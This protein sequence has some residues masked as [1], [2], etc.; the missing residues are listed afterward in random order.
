MNYS[1]IKLPLIIP[2]PNQQHYLPKMIDIDN[3]LERKRQVVIDYSVILKIKK[4]NIF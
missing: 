2:I 3:R 1:Y 4:I